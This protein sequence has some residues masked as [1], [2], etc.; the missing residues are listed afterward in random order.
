VRFHNTFLRT[1]ANQ[2]DGPGESHMLNKNMNPFTMHRVVRL[3]TIAAFLLSTL[4]IQVKS[5]DAHFGPDPWIYGCNGSGGN[6]VIKDPVNVIFM[7]NAWESTVLWE[8]SYHF[9]W[10]HSSGGPLWFKDHGVMEVQQDQ[11]ADGDLF[12]SQRWHQ[13][14][15]Q[16]MDS[17]GSF[18][19]TYTMG[20]AHRDLWTWCTHIADTSNGGRDHI[21]SG[22]SGIYSECVNGFET[23]PLGI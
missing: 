6:C 8:I 11:R 14:Y 15:N 9:N 20:P 2:I 19:G 13:R 16:S 21:V 17:G 5:A 7:N 10:S 4:A 18:W 12:A 22:M 3:L 1:I 23:T